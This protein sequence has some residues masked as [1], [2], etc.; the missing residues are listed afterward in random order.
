LW[1]F[2]AASPDEV[3]AAE[4]ALGR[5]AIPGGYF[6]VRSAGP[7][8]PRAL[9]REGQRLR[10]AWRRAVPLNRRVNELLQADRQLLA[11]TCTPYG[12]L[13][14]PGISPHWPPVATT[15]Q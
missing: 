3:A 14:D 6:A 13:A 7:L 4:Q 9:L 12:D 5:P 8:P 10:L 1:I 2:Y 15:H 11:G